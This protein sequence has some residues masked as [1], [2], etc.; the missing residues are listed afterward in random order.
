VSGRHR[1]RIAAGNWKLHKTAT[2]TRRT[3]IELRNKLAG[4]DPGCEVVVCPP[5]VSLST[6]VDAAKETR[7][8]V[9]AQNVFWEESGAF[10]GEVSASMLEDVGVEY[11]IIGH[12]ERRAMFGE[13]DETV[14]RKLSRV[15]AGSLTP[16]VCVGE[17]LEERESGATEEVLARQVRGALGGVAPD[18]MGRVVVA[19][20]PVWAIGTGKTASPVTANE[21]HTLI[22]STIA[23]IFGRSAAEE[24]SVLYGGSVKPENVSDLVRQSEVDGVLV[25]GASLDPASFAEIVRAMG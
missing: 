8:R 7:I 4:V 3:I 21:A 9:G 24:T 18:E 2:E 13:T 16:I 10:T 19:Y 17:V 12:S 6:A 22:R 15:L 25:G 23:A 20:E 1:Q 14:S 11:V 5:M